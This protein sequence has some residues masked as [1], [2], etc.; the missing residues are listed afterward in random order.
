MGK[1]PTSLATLKHPKLVCSV[2]ALGIIAATGCHDALV[3][4]WSLTN[5]T[6]LHKLEHGNGSALGWRK[7][8]SFG[9]RG[10]SGVSWISTRLLGGGALLSGSEGGSVK[11]WQL[12][13][14]LLEA[15]RQGAAEDGMLRT[16]GKEG[17]TPPEVTPS[18]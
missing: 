11:L 12:P 16:S 6:C 17:D 18:A 1:R 2:S 4:L 7:Q 15:G 14:R 8:Q 9:D 13:P 5:F 10:V 3:R